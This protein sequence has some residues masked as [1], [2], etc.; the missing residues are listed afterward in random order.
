[1]SR[2]VLVVF[3]AFWGIAE[4]CRRRWVYVTWVGVSTALLAWHAV[5]FMSWRPIF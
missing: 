4:W 2:F 1:M 5:L 3:P